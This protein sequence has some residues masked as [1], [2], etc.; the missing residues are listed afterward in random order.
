M[1]DKFLEDYRKPPRRE[2][3]LALYQR[4]QLDNTKADKMNLKF[5]RSMAFGALTLLLV[6]TLVLAVSPTVRAQL[7]DFVTEVGGI[8]FI[9]TGKYPG[10]AEREVTV[11]PSEMFTLATVRERIG[12]DLALPTWV[13][14]GYTLVDEVTVMDFTSSESDV[15]MAVIRWRN[16]EPWEMPISLRVSYRTGGEPMKWI[17]GPESVEEVQ[18]NGQAAALVRGVWNADAKRWDSPEHLSLH[19]QHNGQTYELQVVEAQVNAAELIR[20]AESIP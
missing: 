16:P 10:T 5:Y 15:I 11:I 18:I 2:F 12:F 20:I 7:L 6:F 13:P 8:G 14:E 17:I 1:N 19:W 4:L 9:E 3:I